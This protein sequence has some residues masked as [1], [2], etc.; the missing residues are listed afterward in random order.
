M[1]SEEQDVVKILNVLSHVALFQFNQ[2]SETWDQTGVEGCC[3]F[4][5]R[6]SKPLF[7]FKVFNR[8]NPS[9]LAIPF[10]DFTTSVEFYEDK[11]LLVIKASPSGN[12]YG[13]WLSTNKEIASIRKLIKSL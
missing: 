4:Y 13:I 2:V 7:G 1:K 12:L 9:D 3:I 8:S 10:E 6:S 11:S 5:Q